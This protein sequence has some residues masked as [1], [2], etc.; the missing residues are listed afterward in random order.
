MLKSILKNIRQILLDRIVAIL[1]SIR[2]FAASLQFSLRKNI[3]TN[4]IS[5][6]ISETQFKHVFC[7]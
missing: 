4:L 1:Q 2:V 6:L 3:K 5:Q 7:S